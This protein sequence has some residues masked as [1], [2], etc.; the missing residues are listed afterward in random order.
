MSSSINHRVAT[1]ELQKRMSVCMYV[2][3][4]VYL[5]NVGACAWGSSQTESVLRETAHVRSAR[6]D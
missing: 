2:C 5:Q 3:M 6:L 4:Y 1:I